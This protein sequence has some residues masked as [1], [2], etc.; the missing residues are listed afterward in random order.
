[1]QNQFRL[2][3]SRYIVG[4]Q[5]ER[6]LFLDSYHREL[7]VIPPE[8]QERFDAGRVFERSFKDLFP[9]GVD[10]SAELGSQISR[11]ATRTAELLSAAGEVTIFEAGFIFNEVLVL[12]DVVHKTADGSLEVF[13]VKHS[14][15]VSETFVN[16]VSVQ[17][18]VISN[19]VDHL[20]R[21]ALVYSGEDGLFQYQELLAD[22]QKQESKVA[23]NI[24]RMK[25]VLAGSEPNTPMGEH[26]SKPYN[27]FFR[28]YCSRLQGRAWQY[29]K[30]Q[31]AVI[32]IDK[33]S[34]L[35]LA[36]PGCGKT[37]ILAERIV[38]AHE[39]GVKYEDMLC[40]TFTNRAAKGMRDR[41]SQR[42]GMLPDHLFVGNIHRFCSQ[43]LFENSIV[44]KTTSIIDEEDRKSIIG[45]M[46]G[47]NV[48]DLDGQFMRNAKHDIEERILHIIGLH[49]ALWQF[50]HGHPNEVIVHTDIMEKYTSTFRFLCNM[51]GVPYSRSGLAHIYKNIDKLSAQM[52]Y[53]NTQVENIKLAKQYEREKEEN[54]MIDFGDL[55]LQTYEYARQHPN[56]IPQYHWIQ[57]D[58]VQDLS[59][60]QFAI[61]DLFTAKKGATE[62]FLGDEQQAIFSFAGTSPKNLVA[63]QERCKNNVHHL[64]KNYR[65]PK[66]LLDIFNT[67]AA[68][69]LH[70]ASAFLPKTDNDAPSG[71]DGAM[72]IGA[73]NLS[74]EAQL[75]AMLASKYSAGEDER[76]A[77]IV[78]SNADADTI[79]KLLDK[80]GLKH[81]KVS[82]VDVFSLPVMQALIAHF[83]VAVAE[84][85][86]I[87]WAKLF[88]Y[89]GIINHYAEARG[90]LQQMRRLAIAPTDLL[91]LDKRTYLQD[92]AD[93]YKDETLVVFDTETT[94]LNVFEN[95]IVQIA[96]VK[97]RN[98]VVV[99]GSVFNIFLETTQPIPEM[100]GDE[101]NPLIEE[102]A[103]HQKLSRSEGLKQFCEYC[104]GCILVGHNVEFDYHI[105]Q[106]NLLRDCPA[107]DLEQQHPVYFDTL[108]LARLVEPYLRVYKLKSLLESLHLEGTNSHLANDDIMATKS[109]LDYC[110]SMAETHY[111][112]QQ[113]AFLRKPNIE[114]TA[115]KIQEK[116]KPLYDRT[117]QRLYQR[118]PKQNLFADELRYIYKAIVNQGKAKPTDKFAYVADYFENDVVNPSEFPS[119][120]EQLMAYNMELNTC[121]EVDLCDSKSMK[122]RVFVSTVH[123]AK[124][125]EFETVIVF[126]AVEGRY[127][128]F[129]NR[130]DN[131]VSGLEE[132]ARRFYVA[133]SRAKRRLVITHSAHNNMGFSTPPSP[134]LGPIM[135]KLAQWCYD[136][137]S[138]S[139]Y[140]VGEGL[141][142]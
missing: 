45:E 10:L 16:D 38:Q 27:C 81:F 2:T 117:Q 110:F 54:Q 131:N 113:G 39:K 20:V 114:Q 14:P 70:T 60:L 84:L 82:G 134:F 63:L 67:Y 138:N 80:Q 68:Q 30:D 13:E 73:E 28:D 78:S 76:V 23:R 31:H 55:L 91:R 105:L 89:S 100:L 7:A 112:K 127:P 1:M 122:E 94:G 37:A 36:P 47:V 4:L 79:S 43:F 21:F 57:V 97:V 132:D 9:N 15:K 141:I 59:A 64:H 22:A 44:S 62:V 93:A 135:G 71:E 72:M 85:S 87:S 86:Y 136:C 49:H 51:A 83:S 74:Q 29:D 18:Y 5:C 95:E 121:K 101:K 42:N 119:L 69:Q 130:R 66:Y 58:E 40:L 99:E 11:Y 65:S 88:F 108:K 35:V 96:A 6:A 104:K 109:L 139:I 123:K 111:I 19:C 34:H 33:G 24:E 25:Q 61:V 26:C 102:Y 53:A 98:G 120:I 77:V 137:S 41:L 140:P 118:D 75:A 106:Y 92:F 124:G 32:N 8:T 56:D 107:M 125:L 46:L 126:N 3:K 116:Y 17:H 52:N 133:L 48:E 12:A 128:F 142:H 90:I 129:I 103:Q 115:R 50:E